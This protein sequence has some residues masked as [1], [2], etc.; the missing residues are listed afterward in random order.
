M[1]REVADALG[2]SPPD[3]FV[4]ELMP[5]TEKEMKDKETVE[6]VE[7]YNAETLRWGGRVELTPNE[8]RELRIP[9]TNTMELAGRIDF[10]YDARV[11]LGG[12]ISFFS[13]SLDL[14]ASNKA[15]QPTQ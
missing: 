2:A 1:P 15:L 14:P 12:S 7:N 8:V 9:A 5:L 6:Y 10:Q 13:L 11:G 3:G 4:A